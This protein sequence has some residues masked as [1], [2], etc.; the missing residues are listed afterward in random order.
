MLITKRGQTSLE[1]ILLIGG[2]LMI[3]IVVVMVA[4]GNVFGT[5]S[6]NVGNTTSG[7]DDALASISGSPP[8]IMNVLVTTGINEATITWTTD[9]AA[10]S[11]ANYAGQFTAVSGTTGSGNLVT[12]HEVKITGLPS[13]TYDYTITSCNSNGGCTTTTTDTFTIL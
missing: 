2:V 3:L 5:T 6:T 11:S 10:T 1:Y 9:I 8:Q 13:D 4:R 7:I 12:S